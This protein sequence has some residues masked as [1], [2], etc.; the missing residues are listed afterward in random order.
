M[1]VTFFFGCP[2]NPDPDN[3]LPAL[4]KVGVSVRTIFPES[5]A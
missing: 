4:K 1:T 3:K 2:A 5:A